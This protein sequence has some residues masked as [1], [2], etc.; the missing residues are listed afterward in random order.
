M[1]KWRE[2]AV[3]GRGGVAETPRSEGSPPRRYFA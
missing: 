2:R 1:R 3:M